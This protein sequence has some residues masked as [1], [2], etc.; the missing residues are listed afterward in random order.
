MS[1]DNIANAIANR[2]LA[3]KRRNA[4][5]TVQTET[6]KQ[7]TAR[8]VT[9][10]SFP[11]YDDLKVAVPS[12]FSTKQPKKELPNGEKISGERKTSQTIR[13]ENLIG[14]RKTSQAVRVEN[15]ALRKECQNFWKQ[16]FVKEGLSNVESPE[17]QQTDTKESINSDKA[18]LDRIRERTNEKLL[19]KVNDKKQKVDLDEQTAKG[20]KKLVEKLSDKLI[21]SEIALTFSIPDDQIRKR[22]TSRPRI[23]LNRRSDSLSMSREKAKANLSRNL[24]RTRKLVRDTRSIEVKDFKE[25]G[26]KEIKIKDPNA[27]KS[28]EPS[29]VSRIASFKSNKVD[30]F[31]SKTKLKYLKRTNESASSMDKSAKPIKRSRSQEEF[32]NL[33]LQRSSRLSHDLSQ[34]ANRNLVNTQLYSR[35]IIMS[36][37]KRRTLIVSVLIVVAFV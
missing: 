5:V 12:S 3:S 13:W 24:N 20:S 2:E 6:S 14:Q 16:R 10:H 22:R 7:P 34:T 17:R 29:L 8:L 1:F 23:I 37:A 9:S 32:S 4:V 30:N 19:D 15:L 25:K 18:K 27:Q 35:E 11:S 28:P 36:R 31:I 26:P 21:D 33:K